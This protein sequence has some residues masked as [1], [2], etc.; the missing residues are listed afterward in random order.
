MQILDAASTMELHP[1]PMQILD[2]DKKK[3][4]DRTGRQAVRDIVQYVQ[5]S[6][7]NGDGVALATELLAE[8]PGQFLQ[9][10]RYYWTTLYGCIVNCRYDAIWHFDS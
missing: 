4:T 9:W 10:V 2:A 7:Y 1:P 8:L 6:K 3:L 5:F